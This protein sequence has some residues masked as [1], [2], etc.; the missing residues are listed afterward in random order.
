MNNLSQECIDM[1]EKSWDLD[2]ETN[3]VPVN[4]YAY[5]YGSKVALTNPTIY[6]SAGLMTVEEALRFAEWKSSSSYVYS[7]TK[8]AWYIAHDWEP[9]FITTTDLLTIFRNQN[10]EK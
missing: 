10:K 9:K 5:I 4:P 2:Q 7:K 6:Q 1:I 3:P 8:K